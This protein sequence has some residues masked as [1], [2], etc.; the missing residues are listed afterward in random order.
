MSAR[1][2]T[3]IVSAAV[4]AFFASVGLWYLAYGGWNI[5]GRDW[6]VVGWMAFFCSIGAAA[7]MVAL[8]M[9]GSKFIEVYKTINAGRVVRQVVFYVWAI[10]LTGAVAYLL[11]PLVH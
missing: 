8:V 11:K 9:A 10:I 1:A 6:C 4:A 5:Q 7:L 2:I 3:F